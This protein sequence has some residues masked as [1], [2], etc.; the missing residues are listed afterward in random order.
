MKE[1][2]D[3]RRPGFWLLLAALLVVVFL[4]AEQRLQTPTSGE[5]DEEE[6]DYVFDGPTSVLAGG[7]YLLVEN[8]PQTAQEEL[9][10]LHFLYD[11]NKDFSKLQNILAPVKELQTTVGYRKTDP[12]LYT[13]YVLHQFSTLDSSLV[14]QAS[15]GY[16]YDYFGLD[17]LIKKYR[18]VNYQIINVV[19]TQRHSEAFAALGPQYSSGT[20][21]RN[22]LVAKARGDESFL[23]YDFHMPIYVNS[24]TQS[25]AQVQAGLADM[26]FSRK[27]VRT[28]YQDSWLDQ[29]STAAAPTKRDFVL[30]DHYHNIYESNCVL[31]DWA[32][33]D[34]TL[35]PEK[36]AVYVGTGHDNC[37]IF[38]LGSN[39]VTHIADGEPTTYVATGRYGDKELAQLIMSSFSEFESSPTNVRIPA[40]SGMGNDDV[41]REFMLAYGE[42]LLNM[43]KENAYALR[44]FKLLDFKVHADQGQLYCDCSFAVL[45]LDYEH[46]PWWAGNSTDGTGD[47]AGWL[48]L[49]R[50][51]QLECWDG[52]WYCTNVGTGI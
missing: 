38:I 12:N 6:E 45:P 34:Q 35:L 2:F 15:A 48:T 29:D 18:L 41:V 42:Y 25:G 44:G 11:V 50:Q 16:Y 17:E 26:F 20:L 43:T 3:T 31:F 27:K 9:V 28:W 21:S 14:N 4:M 1:L 24:S 47:L 32:P 46:T 51:M 49:R 40:Q 39:L 5:I 30:P 23:I 33:A 7:Q 22:Y 36:S 13:S 37:F 52:Y 19:Y 8:P 10:Y